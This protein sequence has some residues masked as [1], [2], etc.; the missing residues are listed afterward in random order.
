MILKFSCLNI[1][2]IQII[3]LVHSSQV[4]QLFAWVVVDG[5]M[6]KIP[7]SVPRVFYLNSRSQNEEFSGKHVN[8]TLPHGR[9]SYNL[10]E[11][12]VV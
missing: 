7:I 1:L 12:L 6:L 8:K 2:V 9:H 4:G 10:Y 5:I 3:Q 11:V